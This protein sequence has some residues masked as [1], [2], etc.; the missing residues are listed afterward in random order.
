MLTKRLRHTLSLCLAAFALNSCAAGSKEI[1]RLDASDTEMQ[2]QV[3]ALERS[4]DAAYD[5]EK[6]LASRLRRLEE[7]VAILQA[8]AEQAEA[9]PR[10]EQ[11]AAPARPATDMPT[12]AYDASAAYSLAWD[13]HQQHEFE[14]S[15]AA[16]AAIVERAPTHSLADNAQYWMGE[17]LFGLGRYRPALTAF[18]AVL[19]F[20]TTEKDDDAQL[21]I[22]RTYSALGEKEQA[23]TAFRRLLTQYPDSEYVDAAMKDLRYLEG[24]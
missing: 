2:D 11:S 15:S 6:A 18:T 7:T 12:A 1:A 22:G 3:T 16:F 13:L 14:K 20:E 21:M 8:R 5:R 10:R 23:V 9:A 24:P 4:M 17:A 19:A